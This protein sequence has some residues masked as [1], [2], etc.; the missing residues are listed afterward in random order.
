MQAF[1]M[2][3]VILIVALGAG[4]AFADVTLPAVFSDHMVLQHGRAVSV[5]GWAEAGEKVTVSIAGRSVS[6]VAGSD[7]RWQVRL[8]ALAPGGPHVLTVSGTNSLTVDDVLVGDVW[9]CSGQSNMAMA[10]CSAMNSEQEQAAANHPQIRH[11]KT[12]SRAVPE[13][14]DRCDGSWAVCSPETV[15][16]F[17]A[18]GYFFGRELHKQLDIP[19]GLINSSWGGTAVEAWTSWSAQEDLRPLKSLHKEWA[20]KISAYDADKAR[21]Q[22][23]QNLDTWKNRAA[24][25]RAAG[26]KPPRKP[27]LAADPAVNPN[28]PAN[29][30]NGMIHPLIPYGIRG[31]IWYQGER[32]THGE[33]S[34]S[35]GL[36][37]EAMIYDWRSRWGYEFPFAWVQ[38][39]NFTDPQVEPVESTGWV[40]VREGMLK[41]LDLSQTGMA[42]TIDIGDAGNIHPKNKQDVG[43]RLAK[44]ALAEVYGKPGVSSGP[45]YKSMAKKG[46]AIVVNFDN[47]ARGLVSKGD[48]LV[49]FTVAGAD[50]KFVWAD[51]KIVGD[52]V[53]VSS[54][55]VKAPAAVRYAWAPNPKCNLY[56]SAGLPAGPFRTDNWPIELEADRR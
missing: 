29:L 6:C 14:Q 52:T 43:R 47:V 12:A 2:I 34:K 55:K 9:L 27:T 48:K 36:Q 10:V 22:L 1:R 53:V 54:P 37:L 13:P 26:R 35:Y 18:T 15:G 5:W 11:F 32:N 30:F 31:A 51:A 39:P 21:V 38:L 25:A 40:I 50:R 28:R 24:K 8:E 17:T 56:N 3:L 16:T 42:I 20:D 23:E 49:G 44:W 46:G 41:T 33:I 7:G 4:S 19:I 45:L